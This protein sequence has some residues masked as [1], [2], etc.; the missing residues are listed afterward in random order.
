MFCAKCGNQIE[1]GAAFCPKCGA[2]ISGSDYANAASGQPWNQAQP[3]QPDFMD[4]I[5]KESAK[6]RNTIIGIGVVAVL[7]VIAVVFF[8]SVRKHTINLNKYVEITYSGY[9]TC[10]T[11]SYTIDKDKF[12][13]DFGNKIKFTKSGK[14][15]LMK[16]LEGVLSDSELDQA[17]KYAGNLDKL[18]EQFGYTPAQMVSESL[19]GSV[20]NNRGLS[21]GDKVTFTWNISD[22]DKEQMEKYLNIKLKYSDIDGK[23]KGLEDATTFDPFEGITVSFT[24]IAPD[25]RAEYTLNSSGGEYSALSYNFDKTDGLSN[26]DEVTLSVSSSYGSDNMD[27]FVENYGKIPSPTE[28]TYTVEGLSSYITAMSELD[29]DTLAKMNAQAQDALKAQAAQSWNSEVVKLLSADYIGA[30]FLAE[31]PGTEMYDKNYVNLVYKVKASVSIPEEG[32]YNEISFYYF[33]RFKNVMKL[34]DGTLSFDLNNYDTPSDSFSFDTGINDGWWGT[35]SYSFRGYDN[36][37]TMFNKLVTQYV[38]NYS[39][40]S[41]VAE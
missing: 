9:N 7:A 37:D 13:K 41:T 4:K 20:D 35:Y 30:Y 29:Q 38:E 32:Y 28:K 23:V 6:Q 21:N 11:A 5:E 15:S 33:T 18:L 14:K 10:G 31:K 22:S 16:D 26:G 25:G 12:N 27:Y 24:G 19:Y 36:T 3:A 17:K 34:D 2:K 39:Y 1:D 8:F 40:E